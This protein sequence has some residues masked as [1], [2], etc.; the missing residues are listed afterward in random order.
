VIRL[1]HPIV[2]LAL[3]GALSGGFASG[4][5]KG[6]V[7][8]A[9]AAKVDALR[10]TVAATK[11]REKN[12]REVGSKSDRDLCIELTKDEASCASAF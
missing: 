10:Q 7:D 9:Q 2:L 1:L 3:L 11:E 8:A 5:I 12:Q 4:Y 6:R